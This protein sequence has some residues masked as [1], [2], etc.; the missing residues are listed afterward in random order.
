M[1]ED[2]KRAIEIIKPLADELGIKVEATDKLLFMDGQAI[3]ISANS[4][5]ATLM[6]MAG[7]IFS[8]KYMKDFRKVGIDWMEQNDTIKRYW[9]N[10][11]T[12]Q[13]L[14]LE[15]PESEA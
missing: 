8:Q 12:F 6:E 2:T 3:G 1:T 10:K 4:T 13:K 14:G 15:A 5:F 7:W 11:D 9:I